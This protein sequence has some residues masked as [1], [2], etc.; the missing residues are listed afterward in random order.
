MYTRMIEFYG[1]RIKSYNIYIYMYIKKK[2]QKKEGDEKGTP[3]YCAMFAILFFV[4]SI[5][6][7][8]IRLI[9]SA[10]THYT[11]VM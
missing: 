9:L 3:H 1:K 6:G 2:K 5:S 11:N 8:G 4:L 7:N 10:R